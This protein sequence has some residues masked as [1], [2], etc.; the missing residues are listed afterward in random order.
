MEKVVNLTVHKNNKRQRTRKNNR[1]TMIS[2]AKNMANSECVAGFYFV[3]WNETGVK[4]TD[5]LYDPLGAVGLN[6]LSTFVGG[7][8]QRKVNEI[9]NKVE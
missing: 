8:A 6:Q 4:H 1:K 3:S 5:S 7:S 2:E 9:D